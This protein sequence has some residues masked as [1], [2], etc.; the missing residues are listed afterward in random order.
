MQH[1]HIEREDLVGR[2]RTGQ[3]RGPDLEAFEVH[4]IGC[5]TCQDLLEADRLLAQGLAA[6][7]P[8]RRWAPLALAA[9]G[10]LALL[11]SGVLWTEWRGAER[12]V[13]ELEQAVT[14][15][16]TPTASAPVFEFALRRASGQ[17]RTRLHLPRDT[18]WFT[19]EL[20]VPETAAECCAVRIED[21]AGRTVWQGEAPVVEATGTVRVLLAQGGLQPGAYRVLLSEQG[22][23]PD[24]L[25]SHEFE[26]SPP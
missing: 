16:A 22:P 3:L 1:A 10:L 26:I 4:L 17:A 24:L 15:L 2:Y 8:T 23:E 13:T 6:G 7:A 14:A 5:A 12:R 18:R 9:S 20:E 19:L 21:A 25:A 11:V